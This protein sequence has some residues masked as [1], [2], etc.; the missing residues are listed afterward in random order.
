MAVTKIA[1]GELPGSGIRE[2]GRVRKALHI[3]DSY[4]RS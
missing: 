3:P 1:H 2:K 4:R